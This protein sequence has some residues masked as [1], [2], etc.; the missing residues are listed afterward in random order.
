MEEEVIDP[1][2]TDP[3]RNSKGF[4]IHTDKPYAAEPNLK[5]LYDQGHQTPQEVFFVRNHFPVPLDHPGTLKVITNQSTEAHVWNLDE[6]KSMS[7]TEESVTL[8]CA[9]N[10]RLTKNC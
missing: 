7:H 1:F 4:T 10:K 3:G 6:L 9:G 8:Q 5:M 2:A